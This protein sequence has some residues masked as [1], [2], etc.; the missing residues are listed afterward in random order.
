MVR[1]IPL[2]DFFR[3]AD[4]AAFKIS[5]TGEYLSWMEPYQTRYNVFVQN[6]QTG[7]IHRVTEALLR[8]VLEYFWAAKDRLVY[9]MDKGG[10]E[11][12]HLYGVNWDGSN[13]VDFTPYEN[14]KCSVV[15][16]LEDD[17]EHILFQ[18]NKRNPEIFD[19]FRLN[20]NSGEMVQ[21]AEN[22]GNI[23]SWH[24]DHDG[25]LRLASTSDGVNQSILYR[26]TETD[27]WQELATYDF[28]ESASPLFF[29]FDNKSFYVSSNLGRDKSAIY[30]FDLQTRKPGKLIYEHPDVDV[31]YLLYSRPRKTITG[32]WFTTDKGQ[33]YFLDDY[34]K[35]IQDFVDS[36]LPGYQNAVASTDKDEKIFLIISRSDR[37]WGSYHLLDIR[38][39]K[40]TKL[41]EL[42][43]WIKETEMAE[44]KPIHYTARDGVVINGYLTLPLDKEV[45]DLP[46]VINPH[47]GPWHRDVWCYNSE[48]QFL[49]NRG[50]A[51]LQMNFRGSTGYGK[52]FWE[53]SFK[54]W[55]LTM[56]D[57]IT[58]GVNWLI[59]QGIADP[60][61]IAIYGGSYGG[62]ATLMGIVKN[63]DLYA[64][65]VD[66]VGV[67]NMFTFLRSFPPYW[68]PMK[69]M[70]YA[71]A[72]D[73]DKD[74][75]MLTKVSPALNTDKIKT[76]LFIAQ[77]ANDPRVKKQESDQVVDALR[78]RGVEVEYMVK[79]NE[80]HG[81]YNEENRFDF[82]R[83]ME[84][85][86]E[87]HLPE[88]EQK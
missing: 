60:K 68:L 23:V 87:K 57:D 18:M 42:A 59:E 46:V 49:A 20:L 31:S 24:T 51:V 26:D 47:G 10:D 69:E 37:T 74:V 36:S 82:Y 1:Q 3:N 22:P 65:A 80:G 38:T 70:M 4:K 61:R 83:S 2:E 16:D 56:Q 13:P 28:R 63:P 45:K 48:V 29:T 77:G 78:A 6:L 71:M 39:W 67:S 54:Q 50:F 41:Y 81:F 32:V 27:P 30:E 76:P 17:D 73:P 79:D 85:F 8:G 14:V 34:R 43:P 25:K 66:Y 35:K 19:V 33:Y 62:Y 88:S 5:P 11:N 86:L 40:L 84:A 53:I 12:H 9:I 75:E 21:I 52:K 44:M 15:D 72:G 55:G 7:E 64:A 58:D